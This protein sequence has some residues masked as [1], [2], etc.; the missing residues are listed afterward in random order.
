MKRLLGIFALVLAFGLP[1]FSQAQSMTSDDQ[2]KFNGYYQ[3]WLQDKQNDNRDDMVSTE[4]H[5]Q[6]LMSKY[7][8]PANTPYDEVAA[9]QTAAPA[10]NNGPYNNGPYSNGNY[11]DRD[12]RAGQWQGQLSSDDQNKFNS[13]YTKWQDANAKNDRGGID[14]HARNMEQIM[15][16][17]NIPPDTPFD[18]IAST[19]GYA[20]HSDV[21]QYQGRFSA[22]DQKNYD[23]DY[24]HWDKDRARNDRGDMEKQ[25]G[26]M[27]EIMARYNI[28]RD[29]P[30]RALA[31]GNR[32]Y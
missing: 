16:R 14:K 12:R 15:Q 23:K 21:R 20:P 19:G 1:A 17:Y 6:D 26:K 32:G 8:I 24:E 27:Q 3:R 18:Q 25:E 29:V 2:A 5:M 4:H 9:A 10:Y 22:D 11:A 13:E 28:P 30:Y 31:S 7:Q